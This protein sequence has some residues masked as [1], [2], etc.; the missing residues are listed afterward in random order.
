MKMKAYRISYWDENEGLKQEWAGSLRE[1]IQT[2]RDIYE[3]HS[4]D[5]TL[6]DID[7]DK[8]EI[9]TDKKHLLQFLN[10]WAKEG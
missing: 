10:K 6:Q 3:E 5:L 9:L 7:I 4:E 2:R 8:I 1:A